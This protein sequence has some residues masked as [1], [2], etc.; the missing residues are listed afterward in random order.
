MSVPFFLEPRYEG[1]INI[2]LPGGEPVISD[3]LNKHVSFGPYL[4]KTITKFAEYKDLIERVAKTDV[5]IQ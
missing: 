1:N 3:N 5:M 4:F 2:V